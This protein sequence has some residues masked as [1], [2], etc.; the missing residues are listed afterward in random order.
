M[1][2]TWVDKDLEINS[3]ATITKD[4]KGVMKNIKDL[5]EKISKAVCCEILTKSVEVPVDHSKYEYNKD[6]DIEIKI[7]VDPFTGNEIGRCY[8]VNFVFGRG[9]FL[10]D[11][12]DAGNGTMK[13]YLDGKEDEGE[14]FAANLYYMS[15]NGGG[16]QALKGQFYLPKEMDLNNRSILK[17]NFPIKQIK[18]NATD[19]ELSQ[20]ASKLTL[21]YYIQSFYIN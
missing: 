15:N 17:I 1:S 2:I 16:E 6:L 8:I 13:W 4:E 18:N 5:E 10:R 7:D 19:L 12:Y 14:Y 3:N 11:L 9:N 21:N 20:V